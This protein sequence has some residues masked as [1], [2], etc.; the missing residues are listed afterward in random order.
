MKR[1]TYAK[2][3]LNCAKCP[4]CRIAVFLSNCV[5]IECTKPK[6]DRCLLCKK[7]KDKGRNAE[8]TEYTS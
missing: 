5:M 3:Y 1:V 6:D 4:Y 7:Q 8:K 2:Y